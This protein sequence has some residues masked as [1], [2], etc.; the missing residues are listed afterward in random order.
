MPDARKNDP[1]PLLN[2]VIAL[3]L[4]YSLG[5]H[6]TDSGMASYDGRFTEQK[7]DRF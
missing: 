1:I 2:D 6:R 3:I 7:S 5:T 4:L